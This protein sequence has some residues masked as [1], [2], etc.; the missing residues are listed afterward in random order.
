MRRTVSGWGISCALALFVMG[1]TGTDADDADARPAPAVDA[2]LDATAPLLDAGTDSDVPDRG[3]TPDPDAAPMPQLACD[4]ACSR[5]ARCAI[6]R[7]EDIGG[8]DA[9]GIEE[10]CG[11]LCAMTPQLASVLN[12]ADGCTTVVDFGR[13]RLPELLGDACGVEDM[14]DPLPT[15]IP[16][17]YPCE[18]TEQCLGGFC[19]RDDGTCVTDYHCRPESETC[20]DGTCEPAQFAECRASDA[21]AE[22]QECRSFSADPFAPGLCIHPCEA[23]ADCPYSESCQEGLGNICYFE[24]CGPQTGNGTLYEDCT[25]G[26]FGGTCYP[27]SVDQARQGQPGY[28]IEAGTAPVGAPCDNEAEGRDP[29]SAALRCA[30]GALCFADGDDPLDPRDENDERGECTSLCDPRAPTTCVEGEFCLDFSAVDDPTTDFDETQF[31]GV[32]YRSD[33]AAFGGD[34]CPEGQACRILATST[35]R[36]TCVPDGVVPVG[37]AC[38]TIDDCLGTAICGGNNRD[39]QVCI[40]LCR[41]G[42]AGECAADQFC[43]SDPGQVVGFCIYPSEDFPAPDGGIDADGGLDGGIYEADG[44]R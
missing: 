42:V 30:P 19:V 18:D 35:D 8:D 29:A 17:P 33:C 40:A 32:C 10:A 24:F 1:C 16:C 26:Q 39:M 21:C 44:G 31:I 36:G 5:L 43:Y 41:P 34:D 13:D 12:G 3:P 11:A 15:D 6:E 9:P 23:D 2:T 20:D 38:E 37:A 28:C 22:D 27:L 25:V 4:I 7:C 14:P